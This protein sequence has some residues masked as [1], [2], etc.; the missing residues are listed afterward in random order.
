MPICEN[1]D[2]EQAKSPLIT[3]IGHN[4]RVKCASIFH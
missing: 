2:R 1:L 3:R 4:D